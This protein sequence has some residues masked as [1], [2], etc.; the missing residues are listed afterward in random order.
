MIGTCATADRQRLGSVPRVLLHEEP[1]VAR[2]GP[3]ARAGDDSDALDAAWAVVGEAVGGL[4]ADLR[5]A[6]DMMCD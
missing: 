3:H 5:R 4:R 2:S 1:T 6:L